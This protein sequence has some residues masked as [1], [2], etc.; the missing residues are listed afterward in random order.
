ELIEIADTVTE[1][2]KI[3]HAFDLSINAEQGLEF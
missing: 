2:K 3:K 1:M